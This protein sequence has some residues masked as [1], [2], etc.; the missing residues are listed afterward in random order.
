MA[1]PDIAGDA[2]RAF[3]VIRAGGIGI[4]PMDVGYSIIGGSAAA[5]KRIFAAKRRA[6]AKLNA[7]VADNAIHREVHIVDRRGAEIVACITEDY[8]LPLGAI[9]PARMDHPLLAKP[10]RA[11][12]SPPARRTARSSC[13]STPARST[14]KS[15]A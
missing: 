12:R 14:A 13:C 15:A 1:R 4:L 5:L 3:D 8:D 7:M 9:A 2:R 10:C 6:P 11:R